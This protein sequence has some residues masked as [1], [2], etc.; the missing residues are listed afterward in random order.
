MTRTTRSKST[1]ISQTKYK[2][3]LV[4]IKW[5]DAASSHGWEEL[6]ETDIEE[7]LALTVG[8]LIKENGSRVVI[9]ATCGTTDSNNRIQIPRG[10][11]RSMRVLIGKTSV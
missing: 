11:I 6:E 1:A 4:E 7:E 3:D 8:F 10:M 5:E 2:Y 9:A